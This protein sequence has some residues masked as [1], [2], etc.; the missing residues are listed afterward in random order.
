MGQISSAGQRLLESSLRKDF[1]ILASSDLVYLDSGA[2]TQKPRSVIDAVSKTYE[3]NYA[4]IHRGVYELSQRAT[5]LY[6]ASREKVQRFLN[7]RYHEEIIFT[8]NAT[9]AIN[10]VAYSW[11]ERFAAPGDEI[12]ITLLEHHANFVP[13]QLLEKR[14]GVKVRYTKLNADGTLSLDDFKKKLSGRTKL[15]A[16]TLLA[17]GIGLT[18]PVKEMI[19]CAKDVGAHVL[20]DAAQAVAHQPVDVQALGADFLAFSGH[21]LYGPSG[22]GALWGRKE[23]LVEMPPYQSGGDMVRSVS[24]E[25][26]TF[27]ALPYRFEAGTPHISGAI[28]LG[29]AIDYVL[30][31]GFDAIVKHE[32]QLIKLLEESLSSIPQ[33]GILGPIGAHHALVC[34]TVEGVHPHDLAQFL[35][36]EGIAIR[37]GHHCAQPLLRHFGLS[38][39]AR[40]SLGV[41]NQVKDI[42]E[43][44]EAIRKAVTFFG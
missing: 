6:E 21:K 11:G 33:V 19:A 16:F 34:F 20:L 13:W 40:A 39:S 18:P 41:Y 38:S 26:T 5:E 35:D 14:R 1:P 43:L 32:A 30:D 22:I 15:V 7:A 12:L 23:I 24:T 42:L 17:N 31:I 10:L 37:A 36:R 9:E 8:R 3:E 29:A 4:N 28:G 27:N 44:A 2:T 25:E